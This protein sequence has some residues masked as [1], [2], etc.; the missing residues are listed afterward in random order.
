MILRLISGVKSS[1]LCFST[2]NPL[3]WLTSTSLVLA[4]LLPALSMLATSGESPPSS[5]PCSKLT[6]S[7]LL[8][9]TSA[10]ADLTPGALER[11]INLVQST[12]DEDAVIFAEI[13][14]YARS[15][16]P[17]P[18][19][20]ELPFPGLPQLLPYKL[21]RA[22]WA[23]ELGDHDLAKRYVYFTLC[24]T[25]LIYQILYRSRVRLESWKDWYFPPL[26]SFPQ[27]PRRFARATHW[28][29]ID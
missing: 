24:R 20:Q 14:E 4:S 10:F 1:V 29:T 26:T 17:V 19:G 5:P 25:K 15:L 7:S 28:R 22:W 11:P 12:R 13:A 27:Q 8:S 16:I 9:P 23:A 3:T 6:F 21:H 18:K 2:A